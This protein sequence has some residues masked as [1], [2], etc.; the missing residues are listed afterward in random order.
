VT[1]R[2]TST[3]EAVTPAA[4]YRLQ[5]R[6]GF[7]FAEAARIAGYLADLGVTHAYLSPI[8][9]AAPGSTHGYDV[10]DHS[11][12]SADLGGETGFRAMA[13]EFRRHGLGVVVDVVPNHMAIPAPEWLNRQLWSVLR[14]G[15]ESPF[16]H[17]FDVDWAAGS[18]KMLLPIVAG[19]IDDNRGDIT[20][21]SA[22]EPAAGCPEEPVL[23]YRHHALPLRPGTAGLPMADLLSAQ[24]YRLADW[25]S[26]ATELNWRRFFDITSLIAVRIEDPEVFTA[27]HALLLNLMADG[28]I[29]GLRIDH[30]DGLADPGGYLD[31]L[32]AATGG[33]WVVIEKI[34]ASDERLPAGW[35]CAG[36]TGY[37]ALVMVNGAFV[38]QAGALPLTRAY[39]EFTGG[40]GE[41]APVARD[42]KRQVATGD[43]A[44][45]VS[46]LC[47]LLSQS[48]SDAIDELGPADLRSVVVELLTGFGVYRAYVVPGKPPTPTSVTVV[49]RAAAA[50]RRCLPP[51][52]HGALDAVCALVLGDGEPGLVV[53]FQ[54]TCGPVMAKGVED[55][56]FYRWS[57]LAALNEVG[58]EP[59]CFGVAPESF[60][61]FAGR[62]ARYYPATMTTLSTHDTKRQ[63]DVRARLAVLTE[64]PQAWMEAV[65][66]WHARAAGLANGRLPEPDTEY[67]LWQ[68][69]VGAWPIGSGRLDTY[70]VKAIREAK[71]QTSWTEPDAEYESVVV[72][73]AQRIL[74]DEQLCGQV[75]AFVVSLA[76]DT[77]ANVLGAKLVQLTMPGVAD[78]FQGCEL[79]AFSLVDPDNRRM[80]DFER[81]RELLA[82]LDAGLPPADLDAD[83]L[84]VATAALRLR[85]DHPDWFS[86]DYRPVRAEG[87]AATHAVSFLRRSDGADRTITVATRLPAGLRRAG[88]WAD[89]V[90]PLPAGGSWRDLLTGR[91]YAGGRTQLVMLT[92]RFPVALLVRA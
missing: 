3:G 2:A 49:N 60:H 46:R 26:A 89:T 72:S 18:G 24:H 91:S 70:L 44:A 10:V 68:T 56:A 78:L 7:G 34:L 86:G 80:V 14:D 79:A 84:L 57:R 42:A 13:D 82:A 5:L 27:T 15:L 69:L 52:L 92:G 39:R 11:R 50:A 45:E 73:F 48:G 63:E 20:V 81:R 23:R 21:G 55:T 38:D 77:R 87:P 30:P 35:A 76:A 66:G 40:P 54:Q 90:L 31:R 85:R 65:T 8:L 17:W 58:G 74:L 37:D 88:G 12:I 32:A 64:I 29:D 75:S 83:K 22:A 43:L 51:R 61:A 19:S 16:A 25:R 67:L 36:T 59:D 33:A 53:A 47:R 28:L 1:V 71:T 9:Q 62:L 41:F 4:T 6:P